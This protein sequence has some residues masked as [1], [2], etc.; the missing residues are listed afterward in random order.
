MKPQLLAIHP[1]ALL[2]TPQFSVDAELQDCWEDLKIS[3]SHASSEFYTLIK[4]LDYA[5]LQQTPAHIQYTVWKY[6]NRA[7]YRATPFGSFAGVGLLNMISEKE[8]KPITLAATQHLHRFSDWPDIIEVD[9]IGDHLEDLKFFSNSSYYVCQGSIRYLS[10]FNNEH[11]ISEIESNPVISALLRL[12]GNP[13]SYQT[14]QKALQ[15]QL[16]QKSLDELL[17]DLVNA[18]LLYTSRLPNIIS[19]DC[20]RNISIPVCISSGDYII[21]ERTAMEGTLDTNQFQ[22]LPELI[23]RLSALLSQITPPALSDFILQFRRRFGEEAVPIMQALDPELGIGYAHLDQHPTKKDMISSSTRRSSTHPQDQEKIK[24]SLLKQLMTNRSGCP[25]EISLENL[26]SE[27]IPKVPKLPNSI[28][29]LVS[30]AEDMLQIESAGGCTA[31]AILGRFSLCGNNYTE[32]CSEIAAMEQKANPEILFFDISY[33]AEPKVDNINR[34]AKIY[35]FQLS[36]LNYDHSANPLTLDDILIMIRG[37]ELVLYSHKFKKRLVPRMSS[38]YNYSRSDLAVFRLLCDLQHQGLQTDFNQDL[39]D[40]HPGLVHYPRLTFKNF[41]LSPA[42]WKVNIQDLN[43]GVTDIQTIRKYLEGLG[44]SRLFKA[45]DTDQTL[46]FDQQKETD[47]LAFNHYLKKQKQFYVKEA[48]TNGFAKDVL[49]CSFHNQM[50]LTMIHQE[51]LYEGIDPNFDGE[52]R[53]EVIVNFPPGS[54]WLY[55]QIYCHPGRA[56]DL[57]LEVVNPFLLEF[58]QVIEKWFF[59]RYGENGSHI[60]LRMCLSDPIKVMQLTTRLST[61]LNPY[62]ASGIISDFLLCTYKQE[63]QRYG[64]NQM[65]QVEAHFG[66]DSKLVLSLISI[67]LDTFEKYQLCM[68][69]FSMVKNSGIF[70]LA[71]FDELVQSISNSFILEFQLVPADYKQ[72]NTRYKEFQR[73]SCPPLNLRQ[74]TLF[75][76]YVQSLLYTLKTCSFKRR[77]QLFSDV[78]HMHFNRLFSDQQRSHELTIYYF[79]SRN[80]KRKM[81]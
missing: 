70:S 68:Q 38:A 5:Q 49:G 4:D 77:H 65:E 22:H 58:R 32:L 36:L 37:N 9:S 46:C 63:I 39:H 45:G 59:I 66:A 26:F 24:H 51:R 75:G 34:R 56:D 18:Q 14:I 33:A 61:L 72:L 73:I 53:P 19:E 20:F 11:Q 23:G 64:H 29:V 50:V 40:F 6:F 67:P 21:A 27:S 69:I 13:V 7:K 47:M 10:R 71:E 81:P 15:E 1:Q 31:N 41:I 74:R 28:T 80:R 52:I 43:D 79:L 76:I 60:R 25:R 8:D 48:W 62:L 30:A 2:R 3:I 35:D 12:C 17:K 54:K 57:L 16:D 42:K 44:V 78:M 55:F